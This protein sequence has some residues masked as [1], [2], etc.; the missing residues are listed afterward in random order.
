M[1]DYEVM[2]QDLYDGIAR[3]LVSNRDDPMTPKELHWKWDN[4]RDSGL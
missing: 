2:Y 3:L 1:V 4:L